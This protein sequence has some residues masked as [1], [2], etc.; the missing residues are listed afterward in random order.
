MT[1]RSHQSKLNLRRVFTVSHAKIVFDEFLVPLLENAVMSLA[2]LC[3][4]ASL[5]NNFGRR[6]ALIV[7]SLL[8]IIL[9]V[10]R[11]IKDYYIMHIVS[12]FTSAGAYIVVLT[13]ISEIAPINIRGF[14]VTLPGTMMIPR[15]LYDNFFVDYKYYIS[16][17]LLSSTPFLAFI[18]CEETPHFFMIQRQFDMAFKALST[19]RK[20]DV[21][22]DNELED[23]RADISNQHSMPKSELLFSLKMGIWLLCFQWFAIGNATILIGSWLYKTLY[24]Y[25]VSYEFPQFIIYVILVSPVLCTLLVDLIDRKTLLA[26]S[27]IGMIF[28][29]SIWCIRSGFSVIS[30][31][32]FKMVS[33]FLFALF[34]VCYNIGIGTLI[35]V[36]LVEIFPATIKIWLLG[37]A[38]I[39]SYYFSFLFLLPFLAIYVLITMWVPVASIIALVICWLVCFYFILFGRTLIETRGKSPLTIQEELIHQ[40]F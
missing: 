36:F 10:V 19:Y 34:L 23:I 9:F 8:T 12:S 31:D 17:G 4:S 29:Q 2:G 30:E 21:N 14:L 28:S 39:C 16:L 37:L 38:F 27:T 18:F 5:A 7:V 11:V 6:T 32:Q 35:W 40:D 24:E 1:L 3:C 20:G 15:Y 33:P 22:I 13:Y 26:V 25:D